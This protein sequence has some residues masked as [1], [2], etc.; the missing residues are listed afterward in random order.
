MIALLLA[1]LAAAPA[2]QALALPL[3]PAPVVVRHARAVL[4]LGETHFSARNLGAE[5]LLL[6][7]EDAPA[8]L[9]T[10]LPLGPGA[11]Y[12]EDLVRGALAGLSL[13]LVRP[14]AH[15]SGR[16]DLDRLL[17]DAHGRIWLLDCGHALLER[18]ADSAPE[19]AV[20]A[21]SLLPAGAAAF[22]APTGPCVHAAHADPA[23]A[24]VPVPTP[25]DTPGGAPPTKRRRQLPPV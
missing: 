12:E 16:L 1:G 4:E 6:L 19:P 14:D 5:P 18:E 21:A 20:P 10:V 7:I 2:P 15:G 17:P 22:L 3:D 8:G 25:S 9:R 11:L 23:P 13:E 24:H